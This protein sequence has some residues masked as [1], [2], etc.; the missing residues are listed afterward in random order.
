[1]TMTPYN[2]MAEAL[3]QCFTTPILFPEPGQERY[4]RSLCALG[5]VEE[6]GQGH[7][8]GYRITKAGYAIA[9]TYWGHEQH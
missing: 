4:Y 8:T 6:A 5:Y 1:M 3:W 7:A 2:S 9:T